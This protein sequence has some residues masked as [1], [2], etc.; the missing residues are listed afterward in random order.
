MEEA[1]GETFLWNDLKE[2]FLKDF[3]FIYDDELLVKASKQIKKFLQPTNIKIATQNL[4]S[5]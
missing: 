1:R 3:K 4:Y 5:R 2:N